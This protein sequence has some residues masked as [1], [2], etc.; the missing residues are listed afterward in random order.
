LSDLLNIEN[1][2]GAPQAELWVGAHPKAPSQV[3]YQ[4]RWISLLELINNF[5][6]EILG[7]KTAAKFNGQLPFLFKV[8]SAAKPLSIQAHPDSIQA[9]QGFERENK[10]KVPLDAPNRNYRDN[11]HKPEC[12]CALTTFWALCGFRKVPEIIDRMRALADPRLSEALNDLCGCQNPA[13][14]KIF[15]SRLMSLDKEEKHHAITAALAIA[16]K[17]TQ[18]DPVY[19]WMVK[20]SREYPEDIGIFAP[21][22]LNLIRLNPG[23][24]LSL[25]ARTLHA[26]LEGTGIEIM[27]N[28]DNVLRGGLTPKHVDVPELLRV[29]SFDPTEVTIMEPAEND[30]HERLYPS[31]FEEF[32]LSEIRLEDRMIYRSPAIRSVE[33]LLC[34]AGAAQVRDEGSQEDILLARGTSVLV[35]AIVE[36]YRISGPA[37]LFKAAVPP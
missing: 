14:L 30:N 9:R 13:G 17:Q 33:I 34:T 26:Y 1:T 21:V 36:R 24:A 10:Q 16:Q 12:I 18:D 15:F 2:S 4:G 25:Q 3:R 23:Q 31:T 8:L 11:C 32:L 27:A 35:P 5:P 28:S 7:E 20:I 29:L 37:T 6:R 19:R 22:L